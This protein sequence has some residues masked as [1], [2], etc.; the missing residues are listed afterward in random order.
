MKCG[1]WLYPC[2]FDEISCITAMKAQA[3]GCWPI[4]ND[5]AALAE[6][7]QHGTITK[8]SV[9]DSGIMD[10]WVE[11]VGRASEEATPDARLCMRQWALNKFSWE[12]L[13]QEWSEE[14]KAW[15]KK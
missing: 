10:K 13:A 12:A 7:V 4:A 2:T 14:F 9:E 11:S 5:F 6:T 3:A 8:G 15:K 1:F